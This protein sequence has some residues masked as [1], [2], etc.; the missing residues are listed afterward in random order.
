MDCQLLIFDQV[1]YL[2]PPVFATAPSML[3][4]F[5]A[6]RR[7]QA[8][9]RIVSKAVASRPAS[10]LYCILLVVNVLLQLCW[11]PHPTHPTQHSPAP[12]RSNSPVLTLLQTLEKRRSQYSQSSQA[13]RAEGT[14]SRPTKLAAPIRRQRCWTRA[15]SHQG[16]PAESRK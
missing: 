8:H 5:R 15:T 9:A 12:P 13:P 14:A 16:G 3:T 6:V 7:E 10:D 11:I 4:S 2:G 1:L